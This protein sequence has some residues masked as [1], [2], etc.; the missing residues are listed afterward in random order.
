MNVWYAL[1]FVYISLWFSDVEP[2]DVLFNPQG[3]LLL[4]SKDEAKL[5]EEDHKTQM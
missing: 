4:S 3:Y 5:T 2:P 1:C